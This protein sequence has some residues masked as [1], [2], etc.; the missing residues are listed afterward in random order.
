MPEDVWREGD[1]LVLKR[2][3]DPPLVLRLARGPIRLGDAGLIDLTSQLG[4]PPGGSVDW[5]GTSYRVVRPS[6]SDLFATMT[7]GAQIVTP[8][9]CARILS[10]ASVAPGHRVGEAGSGSGALTTALAFAVGSS[11]AVLSMDRRPEAI[12]LAKENVERSGLGARVRWIEG[13]V[14]KDGWPEEHLDAIV[15]DLPE[16]WAALGASHRAVRYGGWIVAYTPTYNQLERTIRTM[17]E[18]ALDEVQ[19]LETIERGLH[20]G[21]GGTR[22]SFDMLGHTGF[23]SAGRRIDGP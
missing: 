13:D 3:G 12:R 18:L 9:D 17:R 1:A 16:P 19:S 6:L 22:P 10:L 5:L 7:R 8:K 4:A 21:E 23:L 11:G 14:A 2:V 20:V 15:L